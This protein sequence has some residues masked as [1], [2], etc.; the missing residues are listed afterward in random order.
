MQLLVATRERRQQQESTEQ[1]EESGSTD[2]RFNCEQHDR[3]AKHGYQCGGDD[4]HVLF[5]EVDELAGQ[6]D[7]G[8]RSGGGL[9][10]TALRLHHVHCQIGIDAGKRPGIDRTAG[11]TD[12]PEQQHHAGVGDGMA[13]VAADDGIH[14]EAGEQRIGQQQR[15]FQCHQRER[16]GELPGVGAQDGLQGGGRILL[17]DAAGGGRWIVGVLHGMPGWVGGRVDCWS[18]ALCELL[19]EP[20]LARAS[21]LTVDSTQAVPAFRAFQGSDGPQRRACTGQRISNALPP[22]SVALHRAV[23]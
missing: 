15:V 7:A 11:G 9:A 10:Q 13:D 21:R 17:A 19:E 16:A 8:R 3:S 6:N 5:E 4:R 12:Q 20:A 23:P 2:Q 18:T 14:G 22:R 1:R